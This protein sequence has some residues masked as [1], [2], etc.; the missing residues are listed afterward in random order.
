M[1]CT[2][3]RSYCIITIQLNNC[4]Y[5]EYEKKH[6]HVYFNVALYMHIIYVLISAPFKCIA[7]LMEMASIHTEFAIRTIR[8]E[9]ILKFDYK[10]KLMYHTIELFLVPKKKK[11]IS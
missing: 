11:K 3:T 8:T 1:I 4:C 5:I 6:V 7:H 9:T 10:T 2:S